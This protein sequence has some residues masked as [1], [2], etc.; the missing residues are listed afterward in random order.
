MRRW[1]C[2]FHVSPIDAWNATQG[3]HAAEPRQPATLLEAPHHESLLGERYECFAHGLMRII[4]EPFDIIARLVDLIPRPRVNPMLFHGVLLP[5]WRSMCSRPEIHHNGAAAP[6]AGGCG[7]TF[8]C[9]FAPSR[10]SFTTSQNDTKNPSLAH[11]SSNRQQGRLAP[12]CRPRRK[13][14]PCNSSTSG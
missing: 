2:W 12:Q 9:R 1:R 6:C 4:F 7:D 13:T 8:R 14:C 10:R 11:F 5:G 3:V